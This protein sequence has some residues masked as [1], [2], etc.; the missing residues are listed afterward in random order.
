M[1]VQPVQK[2]TI[3]LFMSDGRFAATRGHLERTQK[4]R[5][6]TLQLRLVLALF[7]DEL[8]HDAIAFAHV[9][10][11]RRLDI[12]LDDAFPATTIEPTAT[13]ALHFLDSL[14]VGALLVRDRFRAQQV[15]LLFVTP[16]LFWP[17]HKTKIN[18]LIRFFTSL[19]AK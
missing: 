19:R 9:G 14:H 1:N 18:R 17:R 16:Q 10:G 11:L 12:V 6:Q 2:D 4:I 3:D 15:V 13:Q 7:L 8:E 5:D